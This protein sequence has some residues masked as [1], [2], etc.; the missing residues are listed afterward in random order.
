MSKDATPQQ[1]RKDLNQVKAVQA[2]GA[3]VEE[4]VVRNLRTT[5]TQPMQST[6]AT[7]QFCLQVRHGIR[8]RLATLPRICIGAAALLA[9]TG[10]RINCQELLDSCLCGAERY[11][12]G[13]NDAA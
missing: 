5:A 2:G 3:W 6:P 13:G 1:A 12:K 7:Y 9:T 8:A 4:A 11:M 10:Y